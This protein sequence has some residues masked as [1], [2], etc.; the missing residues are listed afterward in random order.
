[1]AEKQETGI[2][3][4][5][6]WV[7]WAEGKLGDHPTKNFKH[8]KIEWCYAFYRGEQYKI[9]D[10]RKGYVRDV[11]IPR[12][13]RS[14]RNICRPFVNAFTAKMLKDDPIPSVRPFSTNTEE[15]DENA[16][17]AFNA[18][19]EYWWKSV[20]D[21]SKVL[22]DAVE[23]GA[24]GGIAIV[25]E[26]WDK[27]LKS[28]IYT[29]DV[30][31]SC[32]NPLHFFA[33]ADARSEEEL[34]WVIH[35]FPREKAVVEDEFGLER[36]SLSADDKEKSEG[37]RTFSTK[38][39]DTYHSESD[40]E[41]VLVHDIWIK[42]CKDHKNGKHV[43]VAGGR[44][45]VD[46]D[47]PHPNKLP[48]LI[49]NVRALRDDLYGQG[50]IFPILTIQRDMNRLNSIIMENASQM[51]LVKWL[52]PEQANTLPGA[53]TNEAGE[54]VPYTH[55]YKPEQSNVSPIA[56]HIV[57]QVGELFRMAQFITGLQDVGMGM[58]PY[59]GSQT[60]PGVV[61]E[62]KGSEDVIFAPEIR[63]VND[64]V[65]RI[66][67]RY[68]EL[69]RDGYIEDRV[70][71]IMG[72]N[73]RMEATTY[74]AGDDANDYDFEFNA[75]A[76]FAKSDE[77]TMDEIMTLDQSGFFD[78]GG[79]DRRVITEF[80]MRKVGLHKLREDTFKDER[81]AKRNLEKVVNNI[82]PVISKY[83][84]PD[85]H[86]KVFT[87]F[88]KTENWDGLDD[89]IKFSI[90]WYIDQCNAIKMGM[91]APQMPQQMQGGG[92]PMPQQMPQMPTPMEQDEAALNRAQG[93]GQPVLDDMGQATIAP[94]GEM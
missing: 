66:M 14:I 44:T 56:A 71:Q 29:G 28:G 4:K 9:W 93:Q 10:E 46:E 43:V 63:G 34:R 31:L 68:R 42:K 67:R 27:N 48:F 82:K 35:R 61:R 79:V 19:S 90:D 58:I 37:D 20:V 25:K 23:W 54:I 1:M 18:V 52:V 70:V 69:S 64:L 78:K 77:A 55:P 86:I 84:N 62:L 88:T 60:S 3:T 15:F 30:N 73:K 2:K 80:V 92:G 85:A 59:R 38:S 40:K 33:N 5:D 32:I 13:C 75:G 39:L 57:N 89:G 16:S 8:G 24:I 50:I 49:Y 51:G 53:F 74:L 22:H 72:E 36:G 21:G 17:L 11:N 7:N 94:Q 6:K 47:N 76:G 41:T 45:L 83:I 81:Q 26:Y 65:K 91:M 12:E 87:D